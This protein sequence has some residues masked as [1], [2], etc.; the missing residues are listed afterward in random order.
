MTF[1]EYLFT[2]PDRELADYL[3]TTNTELDYDY[4]SDDNLYCYG[5]S[6]YYVTTDGLEFWY[7]DEAI[8]HQT[9]LLAGEYI[10]K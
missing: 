8:E 6:Y 3:V 10:I 2:L 9:E 7:H 4:D 1:K 5:E